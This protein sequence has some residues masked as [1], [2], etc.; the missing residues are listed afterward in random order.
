MVSVKQGLIMNHADLSSKSQVK[1]KL[2][3][4]AF[5]PDAQSQSALPSEAFSARLPPMVQW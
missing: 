4:P 5:L 1:S 3:A 2:T